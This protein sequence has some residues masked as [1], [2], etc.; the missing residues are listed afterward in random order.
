MPGN[1]AANLL[2][3]TRTQNG[4]TSPPIVVASIVRLLEALT[5]PR[6][7]YVRLLNESCREYPS[8]ENFFRQ[9]VDSLVMELGY[10]PLQMGIGK[11]E[12]A[13]MNQAI[14][15]SLHHSSVAVVDLTGLRQNCFMELGYALGNKQRVIVTARKD[16]KIHFD[17]FALE[18]L[19]WKKRED[20]KQQLDRFR[21]HWKRNINMPK[22][23]GA[24]KTL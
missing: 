3:L 5:P 8:V 21:T 4:E 17:A 1:S 6:A 18:A 19:Q 16:T 23:V 11:N 13:W 12:F 9:T 20:P 22:L 14:F 2:D 24:R 7:F 10:E 15:D